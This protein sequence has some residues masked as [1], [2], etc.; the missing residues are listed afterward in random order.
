MVYAGAAFTLIQVILNTS[1]AQATT[2]DFHFQ[3]NA[4]GTNSPVS[5]DFLLDNSVQPTTSPDGGNVYLNASPEYTIN[6]GKNVLQG[7]T[8]SVGVGQN[9]LNPATG[10]RGDT[11]FFDNLQNFNPSNPKFLA[12]FTYPANSLLSN[13]LSDLPR[14]LPSYAFASINTPTGL[15]LSSVNAFTKISTV[16]ES[17]PTLGILTLGVLLTASILKR[18]K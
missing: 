3:F 1:A 13:N 8:N 12:S 7:S 6:V 4:Q 17:S 5:G 16:A 2:F 15:T 10:T 9:L 11:I 14:S 18:K